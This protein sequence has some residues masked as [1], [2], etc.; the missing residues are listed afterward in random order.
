M[1]SE[2][3]DFTMSDLSERERHITIVAAAYASAEQELVRIAIIQA[4]QAG[5]NNNEIRAIKQIVATMT[6]EKIAQSSNQPQ[7]LQSSN[8]MACCR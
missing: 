6:S 8:K 7:L 4:K 5:I 3:S 2:N 1:A